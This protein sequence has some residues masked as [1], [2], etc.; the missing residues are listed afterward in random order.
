MK[1]FILWM[2][3]LL[4]A[5]VASAVPAKPGW[6]TYTQSDGKTVTYQVVGDEWAHAAVTRDGLMVTRGG[7]G[8]FYYRSSLTG[9]TAM[10]AHD[11]EFRTAVETAFIEAQRSDFKF[12]YERPRDIKGSNSG[13]SIRSGGSNAEGG[14][15]AS[16][17]RTIPVILVEYPASS[18]GKEEAVTFQHSVQEITTG[19]LNGNKGVTQYFK[20]QSNNQYTPQFAV[21]GPYTLSHERSYY[22]AN[23]NDKKGKDIRPGEMITEAC[24][25]AAAAGVK[26]STF[27]TFTED[28]KNYVDAVIVIYAGVG[29]ATSHEKKPESIW[30]HKHSLNQSSNC[31]EFRPNG[32]GPFVNNYATFNE[33]KG[34]EDK[35]DTG[36][37]SLSG[38]GVFCHEFSH[39]LGLPDFYSTAKGSGSSPQDF[40]NVSVLLDWSEDNYGMGYWSLMCSGCYN[41]DQDTPVGYSAY[42]KHFMGWMNYLDAVPGTEYTLSVLNNGNDQAVRISSGLSL[43]NNMDE[44][45]ILENRSNRTKWDKYIGDGDISKDTRGL[46]ITHVA[47]VPDLWQNNYVNYFTDLQM[48][49]IIPADG[50]LSVNT[51]GKDLWPQNGKTEFTDDSSPSAHLYLNEQNDGNSETDEYINYPFNERPGLGKPITDMRINSDGTA[52][53]WFMKDHAQTLTIN[54]ST[55]NFNHVK[56]GTSKT[57][58]IRITGMGLEQDDILKLTIVGTNASQFSVSSRTIPVAPIC[59]GGY[60]VNV[61]YTPPF[62]FNPAILEQTAM[63]MISGEHTLY[64]SVDLKAKPSVFGDEDGDGNFNIGDITSLIDYL[65]DGEDSPYSGQIGIDNVTTLIDFLL[66]GET[67]VDL[68]DGLVAYYPLDG[69]AQDM[70]G[71]GN[72]GI[73]NNVSSTP[74]ITGIEGSAYRFGGTANPGYIRVPNS[75]SLQFS[76]G[77]TFA[78]FVKPMDW[79]GMNGSGNI[80]DQGSHCIFAKS[81]DQ[82][83]PAMMFSGEDDGLHVWCGS[84][85]EQ[86]QWANIGSSDLMSNGDFLNKWVHVAVTYSASQRKARLYVNGNLINERF[87]MTPVNYS[88]MNGSDL[89]LGRFK[90][91]NWWNPMNG[92]LDEVRIYNRALTVPEVKELSSEFITDAQVSLS[93]DVVVMAV[94][95]EVRVDIKNGCGNY[96]VG[97]VPDVVN[98]RLEGETIVLT[99][100]GE[101]TTN[102]TFNDVESHIHILL[103]VTVVRSEV[104]YTVNGVSFTMVPVLGGTFTMGAT[105]E[106]SSEATDYEKPPHLVTLSSFNIGQTEVTQALWQAVMGSNPSMYMGDLQRPVERVSWDDCQEFITRLNALTGLNFRLPTEAEWEYAARGGAMTQHYKYAGSNNLSE[107]AWWGY[108]NDDSS[109]AGNS[110]FTTHPVGSKNPNELNLYDMSGN[111]MEWCYDW[112][113]LYTSAALVNPTGIDTGTSRVSRGGAWGNAATNCRVS[114]RLGNLPNNRNPALGLRLAL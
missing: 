12:K 20:D 99:G 69:N 16:D 27:S 17:V 45:F 5:I 50:L 60:T 62:T 34:E 71:H 70:S 33:S 111:V 8:D 109:P 46:L 39:L 58:P 43:S 79:A 15:P 104:T 101:G 4:C 108:G 92:A 72:H 87:L 67:S 18:D 85:N 113:G 59:N 52:S 14:I 53:F 88:L 38:I 25:L 107:V 82:T 10:R 2:N 36:K 44:Y 76:D 23:E 57:L 89:Y 47:Y 97:S 54:P 21:Y 112:L 100:M 31:S 63:L 40:G 80:V 83:G 114:Y 78:C 91:S 19:M 28:G 105:D 86:C 110:A 81:S 84:V 41:D 94:G 24:Q 106:Q 65:L 1:R 35:L 66:N 6:H 26:F 37:P 49:S 3:V 96:S 61:T 13:V 22:G 77:F 30:P 56:Y 55:V 93:R 74:G 103:P 48:F 68:D 95:E 73:A 64:K 90:T 75:T 42:E 102:V 98:C 7:D 32:T 29:E 11:E 51:E 9:R